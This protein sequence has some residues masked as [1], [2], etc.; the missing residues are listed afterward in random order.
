[1]LSRLERF[2]RKQRFQKGLSRLAESDPSLYARFVAARSFGSQIRIREYHLTN[3]CNIRCKGC[4]FFAFGHDQTSREEKALSEWQAFADQQRRSRINA[5][6]LIGGEP[7]LFLDRILAF[8]EA[9]RYVTI[10]T[11][12]LRKL[13]NDERY[14]QVGMLV[15]LFGGGPL[16]DELRAIRPS[17]R[18]FRGLFDEALL[19]YR[20]DPRAT[21]VFAVT[22][23]SVPYVDETVKRI[24][25][26][27]N[28]VTINFYSQYNTGHPLK[29]ANERRLLDAVMDAKRK[30]PETIL[31]HTEHIRG[32]ITG[33]AWC[34]TFSGETCPSISQSHPSNAARIANGH[35]YLPFFDTYKADLK[36]LEVCCTSG[37][38]DGC[39]DSQAVFSWQLVNAERA[40]DE[41]DSARTWVEV[42]EAYW[43]QFIWTPYHWSKRSPPSLQ[44]AELAVP[45]HE[46]IET[47]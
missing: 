44:E 33:T 11:N 6:L 40:L 28:R 9:M 29:L 23:A 25:D 1:M 35:P 31:S 22:E 30:F 46:E 32:A 13:P 8:V 27:G 20:N 7:T 10:S 5:A 2:E 21:F 4:W 43:S 15:T 17:G 41:V 16:D 26:N 12:G 45:R 38:C 14:A 18:T 36:T 34:G 37:H 3:A 39:R 24:R 47:C 42:A 19:N